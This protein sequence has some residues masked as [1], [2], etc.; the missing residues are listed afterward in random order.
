MNETPRTSADNTAY[1]Q[2]S[3][4]EPVASIPASETDVFWSYP[5]AITE[6]IAT[7]KVIYYKNTGC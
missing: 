4:Y 5:T 6:Q 1:H 2:L 3:A 7:G